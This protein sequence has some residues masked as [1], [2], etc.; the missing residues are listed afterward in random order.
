MLARVP[1]NLECTR[2]ANDQGTSATDLVDGG[3]QDARDTC[4]VDMEDSVVDCE[5]V[6]RS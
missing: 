1:G 4:E 5:S 6:T 3:T 2:D